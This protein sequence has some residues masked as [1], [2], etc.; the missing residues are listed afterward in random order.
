M[1]K[2][3][4]IP[5]SVRISA[6]ATIGAGLFGLTLEQALC[7]NPQELDAMLSNSKTPAPAPAPEQLHEPEPDDD[8]L[9]TSGT[10]DLDAFSKNLAASTIPHAPAG[11]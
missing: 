11:K 4:T 8:P 2:T 7:L 10:T 1:T 5:A 6:L 3:T 9:P